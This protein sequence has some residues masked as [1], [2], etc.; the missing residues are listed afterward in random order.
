MNW[1][2]LTASFLC[3]MVHPRQ[4]LFVQHYFNNMKLRN[5]LWLPIIIITNTSN[6]EK[7][8]IVKLKEPTTAITA[9]GNCNVYMQTSTRLQNRIKI[10]LELIVFCPLIIVLLT[11]CFNY[12]HV[13]LQLSKCNV[14]HFLNIVL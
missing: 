1:I 10:L 12:I 6:N 14:G 4:K 7:T 13:C 11:Y 5:N 8:H 2:I 3:Q 9:V